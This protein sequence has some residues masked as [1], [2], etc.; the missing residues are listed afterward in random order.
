VALEHKITPGKVLL[1]RFDQLYARRRCECYRTWRKLSNAFK[2]VL[3]EC[4]KSLHVFYPTHAR[5][6][7][8]RRHRDIPSHHD[9]VHTPNMVSSFV[10]L[11]SLA[12]TKRPLISLPSTPSHS[13]VIPSADLNDPTHS[14]PLIHEL[15]LC[16]RRVVCLPPSLHRLVFGK[17]ASDI[18]GYGE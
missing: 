3:G 12:V 10:L 8:R 13:P 7:R 9:L 1:E 14:M 4:G 6:A 16:S 5:S 17:L 15:C 11:Q 18:Q 2:V